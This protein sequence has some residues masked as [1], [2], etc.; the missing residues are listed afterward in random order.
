M[1][2]LL[3]NEFKKVFG[4][5]DSVVSQHM[6]CLDRCG[7]PYE[8]FRYS[9]NDYYSVNVF[10]KMKLYVSSINGNYRTHELRGRIDTFQPDIIH[11]HNIFP[12]SF[13]SIMKELQKSNAKIVYHLHNYYPFCLN[14]YF[15]TNGRICTSCIDQNRWRQGIVQRCCSHSFSESLATAL[16]RVKPKSFHSSFNVHRCVAVSNFVKDIYVRYGFDPQTIEVIPNPTSAIPTERHQ[17]NDYILYVG[18]L[19]RQK[20]LFTLIDAAKQLPAIQ[21]KIVGNGKDR[22]SIVE[23]ARDVTNVRFTGSVY[24]TEKNR[25]I[26]NC[27]FIIVPSESWESFGLVAVEGNSCGKYVLSTGLGALSEIIEPNVNGEFFTPADVQ[28]LVSKIKKIWTE[29]ESPHVAESCKKSASKY[30]E[31]YY[32]NK[33]K[34]FYTRLL[35]PTGT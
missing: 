28:D 30:S 3:I 20:G 29:V 18:A 2:V 31:E 33:I 5:V 19:I 22:D 8:L 32:C 7:I 10:S 25:L 34:V 14:A 11:I 17:T 27:R 26:N 15:Y 4:G 6:N 12:L 35:E 1:K 16:G 21:F 13:K 24:G 9:S 23:Y